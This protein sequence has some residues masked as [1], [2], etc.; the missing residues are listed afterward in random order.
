MCHV[1]V[2]PGKYRLD[3][4]QFI[5][6]TKNMEKDLSG[7]VSLFIETAQET[8]LK[9][10]AEATVNAMRSGKI[11][12]TIDAEGRR[13]FNSEDVKKVA[14]EYRMTT[15]EGKKELD[16][17]VASIEKHTKFFSTPQGRA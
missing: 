11:R 16:E 9:K 7:L 15:P 1:D 5:L 13:L 12:S 17:F 3:N 2:R 10:V 8:D 4:R 6:K 14:T